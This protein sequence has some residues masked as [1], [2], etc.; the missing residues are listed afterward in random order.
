MRNWYIR[1]QDEITWFLIGWLS[2]AT[3]DALM[4]GEYGWAAFDAFFAFV[5]YKMAS[6]RI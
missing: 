1:Y 4:R 2:M 3:L 5:N 6:V